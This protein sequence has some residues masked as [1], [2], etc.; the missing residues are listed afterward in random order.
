[1]SDAHN[2]RRELPIEIAIDSAYSNDG[3]AQDVV[4]H[5]YSRLA[6]RQRRSRA[7]IRQLCGKGAPISC[8]DPL[9]QVSAT[10]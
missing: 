7:P 9:A 5:D 4:T 8:K 3:R 6:S 2:G 1:M 10:A